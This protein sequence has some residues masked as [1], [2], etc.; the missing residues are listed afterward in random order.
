LSIVSSVW[1]PNATTSWSFFFAF[2]SSDRSHLYC[3]SSTLPLWPPP[4][5]TVS[6]EMKRKPFFGLNE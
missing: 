2:F 6:S 3:G 4:S 1:W 5:A